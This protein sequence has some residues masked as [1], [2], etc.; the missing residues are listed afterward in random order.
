MGAL[1]QDLRFGVRMIAKTPVVSAVA[2]LSLALGVA[3]NAAMFALL[4]A[5]LLEP[6]P[7]DDQDGLVLI[8]SL[9]QDQTSMDM[10]GGVA[11]ANVR[12]YVKGSPSIE[13]SVTY[14]V[15]VANLTG[16]DTPEQLSVV[17]ST[18]SI[19]DVLGVQ[20]ALG[21]GFRAEEGVEGAG[22]VLVLHHDYWQ[23]RFFGDPGVLGRTITL[24]GAPYTVVGVMPEGFDMI[25]ANVQAFRPTDFE[26]QV[27]NRASR[28][29]IAFGRLREGATASQ[30]QLETES[31]H[32]RIAAEYPEALRNMN[33][34]VQRARDFFPGPTDSQLLRLLTAVTLFGLL[35]ACANVANLLLSR[36]EERQK[37]V[38][39]RTALGA[40][41]RRVLTQL[42]TESVLMGVM[43]GVIG[44]ALSVWVVG[45][46][47]SA[48]PA[49]IPATMMP[50]LDPEVV[51]ATL[52]LSVLA[53]VAF[54]VIPAFQSVGGNLREA[55]GD[56]ARGGTA[57]RRRKRLRNT[58]VI[59]EIAVALALLSG[60]GFLIQAFQR[61]TNDDQGFEPEGLLSFRLSVLE[62]R[63]ADD[64][65]I[66]AYERE[67][68]EA[69]KAV[70]GVDGVAVMSSLPRG[71]N[72]PRARYSIDGRPPLDTNEM[73]TADLQAVNP[74]YFGTMRVEVRQ[75]RLFTDAD[76]EDAALV[77]LVSEAF[78]KREFPDDDPLGEH[79]TV[80]G[81]SR[82]IVGVVEDILQDRIA[83]AGREG[84]SIYVPLAQA[85]LRNPSFALRTVGSSGD[86]SADVR[87][88]VWSVEADQPIAQLRP[89]QDHIDESLAGPRAI[90]LF[91]M[92]MGG[93][94]LALAAMGIYGVM[95]HSVVQQQREIGIR[96]ALGAG[97]GTVVGM[98]T[99][100]GLGLVALGV[101]V[102]LPLVYAMFRGTLAGLNLFT[103]DLGF[104]YPVVLGATL[105][106]VAVL[107]TVLPARK[108]TGVAPVAA[109]KE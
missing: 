97:R 59:G 51:A 8:R 58:F 11:V 34:V 70:P 22:R 21:R 50:E 66:G 100:S 75:G 76:R 12:D 83:L 52:L 26:G 92:A 72:N 98:V 1:L 95:A 74:A 93:I 18:P 19:F 55:L 24:D 63:Y 38:A 53:G 42:L 80:S 96:M 47:R 61:L 40:G 102:G 15:E 45:W 67:L 107:A 109:L 108:A 14:M 68:V 10:A 99:R 30:A 4:N 81:A 29:F 41:R 56:G 7:F 46:L 77:A 103:T 90:A 91:L 94:A 79:I 25:P 49:E 27:E 43:A 48:M 60:S 87:R 82:Q 33:V 17:V 16:L 71:R 88:A 73:P 6:F 36:G 54:G 65:Q 64:T 28:R 105:I 104:T 2:V 62:D 5:F 78:V 101:V 39:V 57:G 89:L 44:V 106:V 31:I 86:L 23:R 32:Q 85:P 13:R 9:G 84:E 20:P 35:I 69:L 3:A 37:E